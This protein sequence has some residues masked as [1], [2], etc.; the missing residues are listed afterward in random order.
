MKKIF[1]ISLIFCLT[2][3]FFNTEIK[4]QTPTYDLKFSRALIVGSSQQIVPDNTVWKVTSIYGEEINVCINV[5][6]Y[7]SSLYAKGIVSGMYV[8]SILIPSTIRGFSSSQERF[9]SSN[10]STGSYCCSDLN[11]A[12]KTSDPNILPMWLPATT[13]LKSGGPNTFVSVIEFVLQ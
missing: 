5:A 3:L 6:C 4:A 13:T 9:S 8:N 10:C 1:T 7:S 11:C 2:V 12:N